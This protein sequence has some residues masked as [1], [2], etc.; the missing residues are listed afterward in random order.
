MTTRW[1]VEEALATANMEPTGR[2]IMLRLLTR[3]VAATAE[4]PVQHAPTFDDLAGAT[5]YSRSA[6]AEWMKALATSGWARRSTSVPNIKSGYLLGVGEQDVA[7]PKR[8]SRARKDP[9]SSSPLSGPGIDGASRNPSPLTD[10]NRVYEGEVVRSA[11][12]PIPASGPL[13]GLPLVRSADQTGPLSGLPAE[14]SP[15]SSSL[16]FTNPDPVETA[17]LVPVQRPTDALIEWSVAHSKS[18]V[19]PLTATNPPRTTGQAALFAASNVKI[20]DR[21]QVILDALRAD[22]WPEATPADAKAV[23]KMVRRAHPGKSIGYLRGIATGS[24]FTSFY[25]KV[26]E[27]RAKTVDEQIKALERTKPACAHGTL[28]GNELHPTHGIMLCPQCRAGKPAEPDGPTTHPVV[29]AALDAYSADYTGYLSVMDRILLAQEATA[30]H[31][32]GATPEQLTA[33]AHSAAR[34]GVGLF[35]AATREDH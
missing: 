10:D 5:G 8:A 24:G 17:P 15:I 27:E 32:A 20:S 34:T 33:L 28:A 4:I 18:L 21:E 31:T 14:A 26:R 29:A 35:A 3:T 6:I 2:H 30:L 22:D 9:A 16:T 19:Q 11:D 13:S 12:H 7:L 25:L 23:D 1:E